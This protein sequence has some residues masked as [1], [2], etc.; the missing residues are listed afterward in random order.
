MPEREATIGERLPFND[1]FAFLRYPY[2]FRKMRGMCGD[3]KLMKRAGSKYVR[4]VLYYCYYSTS[5]GQFREED[6]IFVKKIDLSCD[7]FIPK[8]SFL[9]MIDKFQTK[10]CKRKK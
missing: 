1:I 6:V 9:R 8:K 10:E 2:E 7:N 3:C 5:I 4:P